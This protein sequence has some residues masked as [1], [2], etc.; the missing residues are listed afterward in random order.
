MKFTIDQAVEKA[1][2]ALRIGK[3][4]DAA[5]IFRAILEARPKH[6]VASHNLGLIAAGSNQPKEALPLFKIAVKSNPQVEQFWVSYIATLI[7][8]LRLNAASEALQKA[9]KRGFVGKD[10]QDLSA[11]LILKSQKAESEPRID[12]KL[13]PAKEESKRRPSRRKN[14][15]T[16]GNK[17]PAASPSQSEL[18]RLR[19]SYER[20]DFED[21]SRLALS[22]TQKFPDHQFSW[23]ILG[24]TFQLSGRTH[25]ALRANRKAVELDSKDFESHANLGK[26]LQDL[27]KFGDAIVS[28]KK[29]IALQPGR[30]EIFNSL[31]VA[32]TQLGN[33]EDAE[34]SFNRALTLKPGFVDAYSNLGVTLH[35]SGK[36]RNAE[37]CYKKAIALQPSYKDAHIN[38]G[39]LYEELGRFEDAKDSYQ[40]AIG[41]RPDSVQASYNFARLLYSAKRFKEAKEIFGTIEFKDSK[42]YFLSCLYLENESSLFYQTL[43]ESINKGEVSAMIGSL[44]SRAE[45]RFGLN[46]ENLFCN[47]PLQYVLK[48]DLSEEYDFENLFVTNVKTI[49]EEEKVSIR[50]QSLLIN[51]HQTAG[52]LFQLERDLTNE[53]EKIIKLEI[54]KYRENFSDSGEGFLKNWPANYSLFGWL[55]S[56][57]SGG[58]LAPHIHENSWLSGSIYINVPC[59]SNTS[60]GNLVVCLEEEKFV[61][62]GAKKHKEVIDVF[63]G[64]LCLFP[65]SLLH[66]TI[67]FES[68]EERIVLAFD[69]IPESVNHKEI[70]I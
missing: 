54:E 62:R 68:A 10:I 34:A 21:A 48:T 39:Y 2:K 5:R 18:S 53:I 46:R 4:E 52:N 32:L 11:Q 59:K 45:I 14:Q 15:R 24:I 35:G 27:G 70:K 60:S 30:P 58:E 51:G 6:S 25:E 63:T 28:Y 40:K 55:I 13:I 19:M 65:A 12:E 47:E 38:L 56:M 8:E 20:G 42:S 36:L 7:Q 17:S 37:E 16:R 22:M 23:K 31:G 44:G 69:V 3:P 49:L 67:P 9:K 64:S 29:A 43:D 33:M 26:T 41:L 66:Y 57:K 61:K 1:N 50:R